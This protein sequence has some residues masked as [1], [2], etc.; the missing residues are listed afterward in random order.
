MVKL[1]NFYVD[2]RGKLRKRGGYIALS[3]SL[4][5]IAYAYTHNYFDAGTN[6]NLFLLFDN[7]SNANMYSLVT[8]S[9]TTT[10]N[11]TSTTATVTSSSSF[12]AASAIFVLDGDYITYTAKPNAT[13]FTITAATILKSHLSGKPLTQWSAAIST[14]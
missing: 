11:T 10:I 14:G 12:A 13:S 5:N 6:K 1:R 9:L 2:K 3:V 7:A 4:S 8:T